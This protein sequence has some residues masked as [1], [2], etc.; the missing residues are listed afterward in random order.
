MR[1]AI[2]ARLR[3]LQ[4]ERQQLAARLQQLAAELEQ[5]RHTLSAYD[6]AIGE[7]SALLQDA[8]ESPAPPALPQEEPA[9]GE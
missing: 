5:S 1:E 4:S 6:G 7:L 8:A 9:Q 3:Q 2:E